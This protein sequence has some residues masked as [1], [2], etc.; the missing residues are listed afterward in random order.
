MHS[1]FP[2]PFYQSIYEY[3][4]ALPRAATPN[5]PCSPARTAK[6]AVFPNFQHHQDEKL[7]SRRSGGRS[8]PTVSFISVICFVVFKASFITYLCK[9][10]YLYTKSFSRMVFRTG[11]FFLYCSPMLPWSSE[12][13]IFHPPSELGIWP[14]KTN[15]ALFWGL[16]KI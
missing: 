8:V 5:F 2:T 6:K 11:R 9:F 1:P 16:R 4:Y 7:A 3:K 13:W 10:L 14:R 15:N 12:V